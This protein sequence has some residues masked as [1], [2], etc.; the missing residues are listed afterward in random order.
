MKPVY[1]NLKVLTFALAAAI[2][3]SGLAQASKN[4]RATIDYLEELIR[5]AEAGEPGFKLKRTDPHSVT[6]LTLNNVPVLAYGKDSGWKYGEYLKSSFDCVT[7][8]VLRMSFTVEPYGADK[9]HEAIKPGYLS[10]VQIRSVGGDLDT[11]LK[12]SAVVLAEVPTQDAKDAPSQ[13]YRI[14]IEIPAG[15]KI[16]SLLGPTGNL[17]I[18]LKRGEEYLRM[19]GG[20]SLKA[21]KTDVMPLIQHCAKMDP[22]YVP[23]PPSAAEIAK[24]QPILT[25]PS[26]EQLQVALA[27]FYGPQLAV[28]TFLLGGNDASLEYQDFDLKQCVPTKDGQTF[29]QFSGKVLFGGK[30][31]A[32]LNQM[33]NAAM[34]ISGPRWVSLQVENSRWEVT[35]QYRS[36]DVSTDSIYCDWVE[37]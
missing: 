21:F 32:P 1:P 28:Y 11:V 2:G 16:A 19:L 10:D 13:M 31:L 37:D 3:S 8:G 9:A 29:C 30:K 26:P 18:I 12:S 6:L 23:P 35:K 25:Y 17:Q 14:A 34:V 4:S 36:C 20:T 7:P 33:L 5:L 22:N 15:S 24:T 27:S